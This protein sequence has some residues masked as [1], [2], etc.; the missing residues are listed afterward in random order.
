M[1]DSSVNVLVNRFLRIDPF[2]QVVRNDIDDTSLPICDG[3]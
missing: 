3:C 2:V 1:V